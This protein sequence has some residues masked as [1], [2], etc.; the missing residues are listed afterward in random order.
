M[1]GLGESGGSTVV[2]NDLLE[3]LL[4]RIRQDP[5]LRRRLAQLLFGEEL[6]QLAGGLR[7]LAG[8]VAEGFRA[9]DARLA[10]LAARVEELG[11]L[12]SRLVE[13][14]RESAGQ[15]RSL[16]V[17]IERVENQIA[18]L[19][20]RMERVE[21]QIAA[22]TERMDRVEAQIAALTERME[23]VEAQIAALTERME[24]AEAQIAALT[25][26]VERHTNQLAELRGWYLEVRARDRAPVIF[27]PWL[28]RVRIVGVDELRATLLP[29]LDRETFRRILQSDVIVS[30]RLD[31]H[32]ERPT[33]WLVIEVS[34]I[35]DRYDVER[36]LDRARTIRQIVPF[37]IP[38]V[39]GPQI[40]AEARRAATDEALVVITDGAVENWDEAVAR[41]VL[42]RPA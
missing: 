21:A 23:R 29:A 27:G 37:V 15:I 33:I 2:T 31:E 14:Q 10:E 36:A 38:A 3:Q 34:T 39:Y 35:V 28:D 40:T 19:T 5:E 6:L 24:R 22:L 8:I 9:S 12:V 1:V 41:W 18:A 13:E 26:V 25:S 4:E 42:A 17:A 30:G 32:P 7:D 16:A 20:E 11:S